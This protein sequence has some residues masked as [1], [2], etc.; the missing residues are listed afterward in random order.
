[1]Y[2]ALRTPSLLLEGVSGV[3]PSLIFGLRDKSP[4]VLIPLRG[5]LPQQLSLT[6]SPSLL[7]SLPKAGIPLSPGMTAPATLFTFLV[8]LFT[9]LVCLGYTCFGC[10]K[11]LSP[12]NYKVK[13]PSRHCHPARACLYHDVSSLHPLTYQ[14]P[15]LDFIYPRERCGQPGAM[16]GFPPHPHPVP[17]TARPTPIVSWGAAGSLVPAGT[18]IPAITCLE[19]VSSGRSALFII[20]SF[21][22]YLQTEESTSDKGSEAQ[23]HV[24]PPFTVSYGSPLALSSGNSPSQR[25]PAN[26]L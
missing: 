13:G 22:C 7:P 20:A 25:G 24:P 5:P 1:M 12:L 16:C 17:C 21:C 19:G 14:Q 26:V 4:P 23:A 3:V 15:S 2:L 10:F 6:G 8:M 18:I 9:I 11:H